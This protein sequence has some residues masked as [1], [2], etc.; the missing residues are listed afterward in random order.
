MAPSDIALYQF[1]ISH[2]CE[3]TRWNLDAKGLS[4]RIE[5]LLPGPHRQVTKRLTKGQRGTVPVLV[6]GG[7]VV[8]DSTD[9]ALH[10]EQAHPST[11]ALIPAS[12]PERERVLELEAYF[13]E[14]GKH[15]RRWVYSTLFTSGADVKPLMFGA[16]PLP[17]RLFGH[18]LFPLIKW[19]IRRQYTL[20]PPKVE[21]SR[22]KILEGLDRLEREIQGDPSRYLVGASLSIA[23]I[24]AAS[25][26]SP[27]V[28]AEGSPYAVQPGEV[29]P[30]EIAGFR[31]AVLAR[32]AGQWLLRRYQEDRRRVA[33]GFSAR[34]E[35]ANG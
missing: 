15:V 6:D 3:K 23:D 14:A 10:L 20:T 26:F 32:P 28:A 24:T 35:A 29:V 21:E 16:F 33:R 17:L 4:Y 31:A 1:P 12:G 13:D 8:S 11:P 7:T 22:V 5:N 34:A 9:I 2:Y 30:P 19:G 25:L 27:L 18:A